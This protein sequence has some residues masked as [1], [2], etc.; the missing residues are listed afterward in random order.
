MLARIS[1]EKQV[2][3]CG[4]TADQTEADFKGQGLKP[5]DAILIA[6]ALE[7]RGSLRQIN[8]SG[9]ELCGVTD[10]GGTFT[11]EGIKAIASAMGVSRSL[12]QVCPTLDASSLADCSGPI[13]AHEPPSR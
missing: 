8:L 12:T 1:K 4:I 3:L 9:N 5:E 6:A 7:F 11:V 10:A 13:C 2:S